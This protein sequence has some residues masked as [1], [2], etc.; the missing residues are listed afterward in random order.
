M[1]DKRQWGFFFPPLLYTHIN[2][3]IFNTQ[4]GSD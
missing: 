4:M 1:R 3:N 2:I